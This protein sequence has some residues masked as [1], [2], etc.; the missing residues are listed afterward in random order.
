MK[1]YFELYLEDNYVWDFVEVFGHFSVIL[2]FYE[3]KFIFFILIFLYIIFC[4]N[5]IIYLILK[6]I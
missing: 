1:C 6:D 3:V 2:V 5:Y 4:I